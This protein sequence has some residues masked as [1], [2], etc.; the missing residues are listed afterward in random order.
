MTCDS[1]F[2]KESVPKH[3]HGLNLH[4][5]KVSQRVVLALLFLVILPCARA[6]IPPSATFPLGAQTNWAGNNVILGAVV[7]GSEPFGYQ[8]QLNDAPIAG[9]TNALLLLPMTTTNDTGIY[10]LVVTNSSGSVTS[11]PTALTIKPVVG[12]RTVVAWGWGDY[13]QTN[14]PP[15]LSG[16]VAVAAGA[17][18]TVALK[19]D[20]TVVAWGYN[21]W[22][23]A[24]V[25]HVPD[26]L[27]GV[28]AIAAGSQH[29]LALKKDGTVVAWGRTDNVDFGQ[30]VVPVGLGGVVSIAAASHNVVL[31]N[32]GTI[33]AWGDNYSGQTNIPPDLKG[34]VAIAAAG[35]ATVALRSDGTVVEWGENF[36][37]R[38]NVPVDLKG[39]KAI[40][41]AGHGAALK[42][43]G[44][45]VAWGY[46][47]FGQTNVPLGLT[48]VEAIAVGT[49]HTVALIDDG[50][51][52]AWGCNYDRQISV[53]PDLSQVVAIAAGMGHT[54]AITTVATLP[55]RILVDRVFV[56]SGSVVR[57][58]QAI[59]G[60]YSSF[61]NAGIYYSTDG[62]A[63]LV[64]GPRTYT[65]PFTITNTTTIRVMVTN[66]DNASIVESEPVT[67]FVRHALTDETMG[68]G[69]VTM[70]ES[71]S[72]TVVTLT[73]TP[74][75]GWTFMS[76][77]GAAEGTSM[78]TTVTADQPKVVRA[79]FG[80]DVNAMTDGSGSIAKSPTEGPYPFG[81]MVL[82]TAEPTN[83][84]YFVSWAGGADGNTNPLRYTI[85][86]PNPTVSASF[87][88]APSNQ[89]ISFGPL[90]DVIL[91]NMPLTLNATA[92]SG[93]TVSYSILS[94][95]ATITGN[96]LTITGSGTVVVRALQSG[97]ADY[98]GARSVDQSFN[99]YLE[100]TTSVAGYG[101]LSRDP[102]LAYYTNGA[103]VR[104]TAI[105]DFETVFTTWGG[106]VSGT[107]N[108]LDIVM[109][110]N[111]NVTATFVATNYG[112][113]NIEI[114]SFGFSP[115][116]VDV[117]SGDQTL[118][119]TAH[120]RCGSAPMS[121]VK[122]LFSD[123]RPDV[124]SGPYV[125]F[126]PQ[127]LVSGTLQDGVFECPVLISD[128]TRVG[129]YTLHSI[130]LL[131]Q[132]G[133]N[134]TYSSKPSSPTFPFPA[135][136]TTN[137]VI[138][139]PNHPARFGLGWPASIFDN[140]YGWV[141][142]P[143][144]LDQAG[145]FQAEVPRAI[146]GHRKYILRKGETRPFMSISGNWVMFSGT[147]QNV[148]STIEAAPETELQ[149]DIGVRL[150][151]AW[152]KDYFPGL[153]DLQRD[154]L[155]S[156]PDGA[157]GS[158]PYA[159]SMLSNGSNAPT[160][161]VMAG[162]VVSPP[163]GG[164][165]KSFVLSSRTKKYPPPAGI[166]QGGGVIVI[167]LVAVTTAEFDVVESP[168]FPIT[169]YIEDS[170]GG[171]VT[172]QWF[173]SVGLSYH[174]QWKNDL[175]GENWTTVAKGLIG[176][177]AI[178]KWA[179]NGTE[180]DPLSSGARIYRVTIP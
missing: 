41:A 84:Y 174:V 137:L 9:Q 70:A 126:G 24:D 144:F 101:K 26:G 45:V 78:S 93:L 4:L 16:V 83:G 157:P 25:I 81:S 30:T 107:N 55:I 1:G 59:V 42:D 69:T 110:T 13:G 74:D 178:L 134:K 154:F 151:R 171:F 31:K 115:Q 36:C 170:A 40:S 143:T 102:D 5:R 169:S 47:N 32:D 92:S 18:H 113:A 114:I 39:V 120:I 152:T 167:I 121:L 12:D 142:Q 22:G 125:E 7:A 141:M 96:T 111:K 156:P 64:G 66:L 112:I 145:D 133:R 97:N 166:E 122:V 160:W 177:D 44:T 52:V 109:D 148:Y 80:T 65:G 100:L 128:W 68:G 53:P 161:S 61:T 162:F 57:D 37:G 108:P 94:G 127:N 20:G 73:A 88:Q 119:V 176:A 106:S 155:I 15:G 58:R 179:D 123:G 173:G 130:Y 27:S 132:S 87:A 35:G 72:N 21:C 48:G 180:T 99:V 6:Q 86:T 90:Q 136:T 51:I 158:E 49:F 33:L 60:L 17:L 165:R 43:D 149:Q 89:S 105:P 38:T 75:P 77:S 50:A 82:L 135:D 116:L 14:V 103:V 172:I 168:S 19:S 117:S 46:N 91:G 54:V 147:D 140:K 23:H 118:T 95:P 71:P 150:V 131:D 10:S 159:I 104:L 175:G 28:I 67:V 129:A 56:P 98:S 85:S 79:I 138:T 29:T 8:W 62:T 3:F 163:P 76:W 2:R 139:A 34:V 153:G 11:N 63:P 146:P 124:V 164:F